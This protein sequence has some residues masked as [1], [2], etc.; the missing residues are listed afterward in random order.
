MRNKRRK[1]WV[2][3]MLLS[4]LLGLIVS[5]PPVPSPSLHEGVP[6]VRLSA[7]L[8]NSRQPSISSF[9]AGKECQDGSLHVAPR[10]CIAGTQGDQKAN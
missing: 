4:F 8:L 5:A 2:G 9:A 1:L 3:G 7:S 10:D 6:S